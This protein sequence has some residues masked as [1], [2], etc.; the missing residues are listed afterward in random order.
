MSVINIFN[1]SGNNT[2]KRSSHCLNIEDIDDTYHQQHK[3]MKSLEN[4]YIELAREMNIINEKYYKVKCELRSE[5]R[6]AWESKNIVIGE[7]IIERVANNIIFKCNQSKID[8]ICSMLNIGLSSRYSNFDKAHLIAESLLEDSEN[9]KD[10]I[11]TRKVSEEE[12]TKPKRKLNPRSLD[13]E[14]ESQLPLY[15]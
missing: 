1:M 6:F 15:R 2:K 7:K 4:E 9:T 14:L 11:K 8:L 12:K 3:R 13:T 10:I 5:L